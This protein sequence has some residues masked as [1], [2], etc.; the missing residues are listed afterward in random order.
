MTGLRVS[1]PAGQPTSQPANPLERLAE[2]CAAGA[3]WQIN[4]PYASVR[5]TPHSTRWRRRFCAAEVSRARI[6]SDGPLLAQVTRPPNGTQAPAPVK[7][8]SRNGCGQVSRTA[9]CDTLPLTLS[10]GPGK[11]G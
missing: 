5:P 11:S 1:A 8:A 3:T 6:G 7:R 4:A 9:L 2:V 10:A